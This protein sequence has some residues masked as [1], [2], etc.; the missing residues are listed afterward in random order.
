MGGVVGEGEAVKLTGE[1]GVVV[2]S[3]GQPCAAF[4]NVPEVMSTVF[5]FLS[6]RT[7]RGTAGS[8]CRAWYNLIDIATRA[9]P[10][11]YDSAH[12]HTFDLLLRTPLPLEETHLILKSSIYGVHRYILCSDKPIVTK[13]KPLLPTVLME[14]DSDDE[15]GLPV[16]PGGVVVEEEEE[17]EDD[18]NPQAKDDEVVIE[19]GLTGDS[20]DNLLGSH[21][22]FGEGCSE[23]EYRQAQLLELKQQQHYELHCY[24]LKRRK[25][26]WTK[27]RTAIDSSSAFASS[28]LEL[29]IKEM[30][31]CQE[32]VLLKYHH[33]VMLLGRDGVLLSEIT[34]VPSWQ[35][36]YAAPLF[37]S[38]REHNFSHARDFSLIL[39]L[40]GNEVHLL[41]H[42]LTM[43]AE[44]VRLGVGFPPAVLNHTE[45]AAFDRREG[46][47]V[48]F[49]DVDNR[50]MRSFIAYSLP[51]GF[52]VDATSASSLLE[53]K[54]QPTKLWRL[55]ADAPSS[56]S[57]MNPTPASPLQLISFTATNALFASPQ[58]GGLLMDASG[59][60]YKM[61]LKGKRIF[62]LMEGSEGF[63]EGVFAH[64]PMAKET[65]LG[66]DG[67][68]NDEAFEECAATDTMETH[69]HAQNSSLQPLSS[70]WAQYLQCK[71]DCPVRISL[72]P[73]Q[74][75]FSPHNIAA[76]R[77]NSYLNTLGEFEREVRKE[78]WRAT[79]HSQ[80]SF[81]AITRVKV[82]VS[83]MSNEYI[84]KRGLEEVWYVHVPFSE[85]AASDGIKQ[86]NMLYSVLASS[87]M[88]GVYAIAV[89]RGFVKWKRVWQQNGY[90]TKLLV[91][92]IL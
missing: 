56:F 77:Y 92:F 39:M 29:P 34:R 10:Q 76:R 1:Q 24:D 87:K 23:R 7:V 28:P 11:R 14:D 45:I 68:K 83:P 19:L 73:N 18:D 26:L 81:H 12:N 63:A 53:D 2:T 15:M 84:V 46:V 59:K 31:A 41:K 13:E 79:Q 65:G 70:R 54:P 90:G 64:G 51:A 20:G 42:D 3:S 5:G 61:Q 35:G 78:V 49:V 82:Q 71:K 40:Q 32:G 60:H 67:Y 89:D 21:N 75:F 6:L 66:H 57:F 72:D 44:T 55:Q 88:V 43:Y 52:D 50:E 16:P 9:H 62:S 85:G 80:V 22:F 36:L 74:D 47:L 58:T 27:P 4:V 30:I 91:Y 37:L 69:P 25:R 86:G 48:L 38:S 33:K 8:V 17:V